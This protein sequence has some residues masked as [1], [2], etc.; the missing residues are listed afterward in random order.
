MH[1][2]ILPVAEVA[3]LRVSVGRELWRVLLQRERKATPSRLSCIFFII[4]KS[5]RRR[6][7]PAQDLSPRFSGRGAGAALKFLDEQYLW[8]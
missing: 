8:G 5:G 6:L 4:M 2:T 3:T 7:K 1:V